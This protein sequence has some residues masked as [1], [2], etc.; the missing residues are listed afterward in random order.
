[1]TRD[2]DDGE[3]REDAVGEIP[4]LGFPCRMAGGKLVGRSSPAGGDGWTAGE[5]FE[6]VTVK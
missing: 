1:M 3:Q 6:A 5:S 4:C 2:G